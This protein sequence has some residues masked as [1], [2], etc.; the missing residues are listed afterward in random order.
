MP[1]GTELMVLNGYQY[2]GVISKAQDY[3]LLRQGRSVKEVPPSA[4]ELD[5]RDAEAGE[6]EPE[7]AEPA[8]N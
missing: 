7:Q 5:A 3:E 4:E 8:G 2:I 1:Q 6:G